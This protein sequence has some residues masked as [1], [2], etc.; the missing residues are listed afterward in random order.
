MTGAASP[1][2]FDVTCPHCHKRFE[3]TL[4]S[5]RSARHRGFK[6]PHCRLFVPADRATEPVASK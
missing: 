6:C 1:M 2:R 5:G 3:G 4:L